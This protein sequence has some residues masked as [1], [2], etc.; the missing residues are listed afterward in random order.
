M[1]VLVGR[2]QSLLYERKY[3][4]NNKASEIYFCG[5]AEYTTEYYKTIVAMN[6]YPSLP[7]VEY[8]S[9]LPKCL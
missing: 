2:P 4:V 5:K 9:R 6:Y 1:T 3:E 8:I 7:I